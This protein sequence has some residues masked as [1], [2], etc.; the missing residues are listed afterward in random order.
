[1]DH[2]I[3]VIHHPGLITRH[4]EQAV[5]RYERLGFAVTP[6]SVHTIAAA[7]GRDPV[8][9]GTGNRTVVFERNYLELLGIV[10]A[11]QWSRLTKE[12][13]GSYD[14]DVPL[15]RHEGLHVLCLGTDDI[16]ATTARFKR[17]G[18]SSTGISRLQRGVMTPEG[19]KT[20]VA[21]SSHFPRADNPEGLVSVSQ[22][23]TRELALLPDYMEHPNGARRLTE[24]LICAPQPERVAD[25]Y[26][27]Y[28]RREVERRGDLF[29]VNL[30][31]SRITVV[32]AQQL[33][34]MIPTYAP[35]S[36]APF[37]AGIAV[38]VESLEAVWRILQQASIAFTH[39]EGRVVVAP[40][41]ACGSA[42]FFE[43]EGDS[44]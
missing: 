22:H 20:L 4:L 21:L 23:L 30:R 44:Y 18:I 7:P 38:T 2:D 34:R 29:V 6:L 40:Q 17:E 35:A 33:T 43:P 42:I 13:R 12:Q 1:M 10:D 41:D 5:A 37:L 9:F 15:S 28:C 8:R 25:K 11:E 19:E 24:V 16:E 26:G 14:I 3:D 27:T 32:D 31:H 39:W 36:S